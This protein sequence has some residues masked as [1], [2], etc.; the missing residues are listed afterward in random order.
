MELLYDKKMRKSRWIVGVDEAGRGPL[1]GPITLACVLCPKN[2]ARR[3]LRG[4]KDSKRLTLTAREEWLQKIKNHPK[5]FCFSVSSGPA[6]IDREGLSKTVKR[7][8]ARLLRKAEIKGQTSFQVLLDGSLF[9]PQK[10]R[11][12]TIIKGDEK[13]PVIAAA[14]IVAKVSRDR[15]MARLARLFPQYAFEAH[16]G[17]GTRLH[18]KMLKKH[19]PC[20]IHRQT[21]L[22]DY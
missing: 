1:A 16:K 5:F 12:K 18:Y 17:Y 6:V 4:I 2:Y 19:G 14:S 10:Y 3:F 22:R 15:K 11:Q 20:A 8:I 9:A 13:V 21:F 7:A